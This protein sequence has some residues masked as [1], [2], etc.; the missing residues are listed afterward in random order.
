MNLGISTMAARGVGAAQPAFR[1]ATAIDEG[2]ARDFPDDPAPLGQLTDHRLQ[3]A[4]WMEASEMRTEADQERRQLLEFYEELAAGTSSSPGR[5]R[6]MAASYYRLAVA[7]GAQGRPREQQV[8]LRRG[9]A[10]GPENPGLLNG[11]AW[12]LALRPEAPP[13]EAAESIELAKRA[14]AANPKER[15]FWNTLGL[16][17]LRAGHW[18]LATESLEKSMELQSQGGDASD[19]LL[20]ALVCWRRGDRP[21]ALD[22]YIRALEWVSRNPEPDPSILALRA[23]AEGLLGRSPAANPRLKR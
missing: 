6:I 14:V 15:A 17:R 2:L 22:W 16:A 12:S 20:M 8:A 1:Q 5:A 13:G 10:I 18:A 23:E 7:L 3:I 19:R 9:L 4:A 21:A 11:L